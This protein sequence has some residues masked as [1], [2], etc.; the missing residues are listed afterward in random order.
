M[1]S[2]EP[3]RVRRGQHDHGNG[4]NDTI[5]GYSGNDTI[6]GGAG[7]DTI[8]AGIGDDTYIASP[9]FDTITECGAVPMYPDAR[10]DHGRRRAFVAPF[11]RAQ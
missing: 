6:D 9:G 2:F 4:G 8:K 3:V 5:S 10:R 7:N 11:R 1:A